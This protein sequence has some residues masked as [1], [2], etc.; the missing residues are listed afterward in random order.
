MAKP[1]KKTIWPRVSPTFVKGQLLAHKLLGLSLAAVMYLICITGTIA[2]FYAEF[3][4]WETP[5]APEMPRASPEAVGRA[6]AF[7]RAR[8][9]ETGATPTDVY[10]ITP[11]PEMPRLLVDY[12]TDALA[13][14]AEGRPAG[15]G[16]HALTHFL[17]ELHYELNLPG[18]IGFV[19]V[20]V[21]GVFLVALIVGGA[22]AL[23]RML[24]D[25]FTLRLDGGR[26]MSRVDTHNRI[27]VWG[28]PFHFV[29]ALSGAI[30]G[31][32]LVVLAIAAPVKYGGDS[33][34]AMAALFGDP[35]AIAAQ[36]SRAGPPPR[37][38][39][40]EPRIVA[41]LE[42][43]ARERPDNPPIYLALNQFG[44]P[45]ELLTIGAR[46]GDRLIYT[47][48]YRFDSA[49]GLLTTDGYADGDLGRQVYASMFRVHAGAFGGLGVKL[50]YIVLGLGLSL[51][52]TTGID[53]WLAKSAERGRP[54]PRIQSAW[55]T[56]V[57]ATPGL[58]ALACTLALVAGTSPPLVF[59]S[60]LALVTLGGAW[61]EP[62]RLHWLAPLAAGALI[63]MLPVV[64]LSQNGAAALSSVAGAVNTG[65][66]LSAATLI[67]LGARNRRKAPEQIFARVVSA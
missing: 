21:L 53:I 27:A 61:I 45:D 54:Y 14:D 43:L 29:V 18:T 60:S 39:A 15:S 9:A 55:T 22:L 12:E 17:T 35:K 34:K 13:F 49:G 36:A 37:T 59:W 1:A 4:R 42:T 7:A 11:S 38:D 62:Q 8:I 25:A 2:V 64:H 28:L 26:R 51:L 20:G 58:V 5:A 66:F 52:C 44:T 6:V 10:V 50:V 67:V 48:G 32:A 31:I 56:F 3:Q 24:R 40:P 23:P 33:L 65:L 41:A 16:E 47:E 46:H 30:M 63:L 57:W 19:L